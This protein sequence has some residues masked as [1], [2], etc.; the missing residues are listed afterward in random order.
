M[1]DQRG[2]F[3]AM[4]AALV[5]L[6]LTVATQAGAGF[7]MDRNAWHDM[8]DDSLVQKGYA[9]GAFDQLTTKYKGVK[10]SQIEAIN[11]IHECAKKMELS[12]DI[13]VDI[14]N[15]HYTD[16]ENWQHPANIALQ[17]GLVQVC[18]TKD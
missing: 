6:M 16:L 5:A 10:K 4:R 15:S 14:I 3:N 9:M 13:L 1:S 11:K 8:V 2:L 18:R 7:I 17:T 12:A